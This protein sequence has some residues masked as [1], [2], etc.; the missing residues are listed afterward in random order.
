MENEENGEVEINEELERNADEAVETE[1]TEGIDATDNIEEV[2]QEQETVETTEEKLFTQSELEGF[3]K[4]RVDRQ[5]RRHE[6]ELDNLKKLET[7]SLGL[8]GGKNV[9]D[10]ITMLAEEYGNRG[11]D[12]PEYKSRQIDRDTQI[13]A[14]KDAS[15]IISLGEK[16]I[17]EQYNQ[18]RDIPEYKKSSREQKVE[19]LLYERMIK[20]EE[21]KELLSKGVDKDLIS[22]EEFNKFRGLFNK[23]VNAYDIYNMFKK[24]NQK[25]EERETYSP[26][27]SL[28][29]KQ[30]AGEKEYYSPEEYMKLTKD[31]FDKNPRLLEIV[32]KSMAK[33]NK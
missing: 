31:D 9:D 30:T 8:F 16:E 25:E 17:K 13:L 21:E 32:E 11:L 14:E 2:E 19:E 18:L 7:Y 26:P 4:E 24:Q 29:S 23:N 28:K 10:V 15:D 6:Q 33:W 27:K 12:I 20:A 5:N 3:M 1:N 22:S